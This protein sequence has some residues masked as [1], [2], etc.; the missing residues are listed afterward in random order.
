MSIGAGGS[1]FGRRINFDAPEPLVTM[2]SGLELIQAGWNANAKQAKELEAISAPPKAIDTSFKPISAPLNAP[3]GLRR[4][5]CSLV[6]GPSMMPALDRIQAEYDA[7]KKQCVRVSLKAPTRGSLNY[8]FTRTLEDNAP[9]P[10]TTGPSDLLLQ[11]AAR[12]STIR[13]SPVPW[14]GH[15]HVVAGCKL[16]S[17]LVPNS[18]AMEPLTFEEYCAAPFHTHLVIDIPD[19]ALNQ[20]VETRALAT[21]TPEILAPMTP[22]VLAP[23]TPESA[24]AADDAAFDRVLARQGGRRIAVDPQA[25]E[26]WWQPTVASER[27]AQSC[28]LVPVQA[29]ALETIGSRP[30]D[31]KQWNY[32]SKYVG[33]DES[34]EASTRES[35]YE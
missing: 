20:A 34:G 15:D 24:A 14:W 1:S 28:G 29:P 9:A 35:D 21:R 17:D 18:G 4:N 33:A 6:M 27:A 10:Q 22:E 31:S 23:M 3:A 11:A 7:N 16:I 12:L 32:W 30:A 5:T 26:E 25:P 2:E 8:T 19:G 13:P